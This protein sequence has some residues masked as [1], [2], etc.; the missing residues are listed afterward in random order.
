MKV[1]VL[2]FI[3]A[4]FA[5]SINIGCTN[6]DDVNKKS[7]DDVFTARVYKTNDVALEARIA[8]VPQK[9]PY[10]INKDM[11]VAI[12]LSDFG[13]NKPIVGGTIYFRILECTKVTEL[14][15]ANRELHLYLKVEPIN[16]LLF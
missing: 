7:Y 5:I 9:S 15:F 8:T 12:L 2:F 1:K 14:M 10:P 3:L 4:L 11:C 13:D 16:P 6:D